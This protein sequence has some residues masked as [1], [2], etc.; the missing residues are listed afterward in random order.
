MSFCKTLF[1]AAIAAPLA[2]A[3]C[4]ERAQVLDTSGKKVDEPAWAVS[5]GADPAFAAPGWKAGDKAAW[6]EQ[7]RQRT[8]AQND[9]A[10]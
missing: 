5:A 2:L 8:Q 9:Y 4:G 3:G 10:R 1:A 6:V 7:I